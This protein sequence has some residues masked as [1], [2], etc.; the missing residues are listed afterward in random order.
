MLRRLSASR[1]NLFSPQNHRAQRISLPHAKAQSSLRKTWVWVSSEEIRACNTEGRREGQAALIAENRRVRLGFTAEI[2]EKTE[3]WGLIEIR[4]QKLEPLAKGQR[5]CE[6]YRWL[7]RNEAILWFL[8]LDHLH[9]TQPRFFLRSPAVRPDG[10]P[11][12]PSVKALI[13]I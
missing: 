4:N 8:I 3:N 6:A 10:R 11:A 7:R 2:T 1:C 13:A 12:A 5:H 9:I